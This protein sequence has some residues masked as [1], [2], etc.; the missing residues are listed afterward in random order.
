VDARSS[1]ASGRKCEPSALAL[2][3]M[4][5]PKAARP[6][7]GAASRDAAMGG[8]L[9]ARRLSTRSGGFGCAD[10]D[11]RT[12]A[13]TRG[14]DRGGSHA[15]PAAEPRRPPRALAA[16]GA[17]RI[18]P[19]P[20]CACSR[21]RSPSRRGVVPGWPGAAPQERRDL[22]LHR[23]GGHR[24]AQHGERPGPG[25]LFERAV[26]RV[27]DVPATST[28]G[29]PG[30]LR[31]ASRMSGSPS[32]PFLRAFPLRYSTRISRA[33]ITSRHLALSAAR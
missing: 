2:D 16:D 33:R 13:P 21:F 29:S 5:R 17:G 25:R 28:A 12:T 32:R 1:L 19:S 14:D 31:C 15:S 6:L 3:G 27:A 30:R 9:C 23:L 7:C 10:G 24:L 20:V 4:V 11:R 18:T 22:R 8:G 26:H